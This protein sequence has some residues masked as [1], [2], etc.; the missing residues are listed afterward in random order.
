MEST[1]RWSDLRLPS[2]VELEFAW[3][4]RSGTSF[5]HSRSGREKPNGAARFH[6][7]GFEKCVWRMLIWEHHQDWNDGWFYRVDPPMRE[8]HWRKLSKTLVYENDAQW[9]H[10]AMQT[11]WREPTRCNGILGDQRSQ[12]FIDPTSSFWVMSSCKSHENVIQG[13]LVSLGPGWH[14]NCWPW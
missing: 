2:Y 12:S 13:Q 9:I 14:A 10:W 1:S 7:V 5:G 11:W 8:L 6:V 3:K 4:C